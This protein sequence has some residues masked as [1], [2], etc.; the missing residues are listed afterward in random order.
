MVWR[1]PEVMELWWERR[2]AG[3]GIEIGTHEVGADEVE[4]G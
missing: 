2:W 1:E 3:V 4:V